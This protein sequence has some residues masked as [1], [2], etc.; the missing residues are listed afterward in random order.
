MKQLVLFFSILCSPLAFAHQVGNGGSILVDGQRY[1]LAD[2]HFEPLPFES[3]TF[4]NS[5]RKEINGLDQTLSYLGLEMR[6]AQN[7]SF[8]EDFVF[9]NLIEYRFVGSLPSGCTFMSA[10]NFPEQA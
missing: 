4:D 8:F 1:S 5:I 3:Y 6:N 2:L 10:E 9:N 7:R